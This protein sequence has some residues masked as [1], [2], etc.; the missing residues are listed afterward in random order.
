MQAVIMTEEDIF[1]LVSMIASTY[2]PD[3]RIYRLAQ[4]QHPP[5]QATRQQKNRGGA[6]GNSKSSN[7]EATL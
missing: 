7:T 2:I 3:W 5:P 4:R 6:F 1:R